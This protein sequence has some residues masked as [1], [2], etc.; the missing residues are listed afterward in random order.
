[1]RRILYGL[2]ALALLTLL[3]PAAAWA[4]VCA[5]YPRLEE[6]RFRVA[7]SAASYTYATALAAS[8]TTGRQLYGTISA[9]RTR[10]GEQYAS[11]YDLGIEAGHDRSLGAGRRV[12]I[13]PTAG[14]SLSFGPNGYQLFA[15][16]FRRIDGALGL[17]IGLVAYRSAR[18]SFLPSGGLMARRLRL[19]AVFPREGEDPPRS[20]S[21]NYG[22]W[23]LG[24]GLVLN[25][26]L[27]IRPGLT[28]PFGLT[29][30][31]SYDLVAPF[32]REEREL[33]LGI[34]VGI[35]LGRRVATLRP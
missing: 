3:G 23:H 33:S 35:N 15:T 29:E 20:F 1:M 5:G 8:F 11:T 32:G 30:P 26:R 10:D 28:M 9:G 24:L 19:T 27:T 12:F 21:D 4:Q 18:F 17:G 2:T 13:C 22:L 6:T 7:G 25:D 31:G 16:N 14:V 34:S